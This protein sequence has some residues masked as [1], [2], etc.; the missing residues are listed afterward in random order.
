MTATARWVL[1][2]GGVQVQLQQMQPP[3]QDGC[4]EQD[5]IWERDGRRERESESEDDKVDP[6]W[7]GTVT[8]NVTVDVRREQ[9]ARVEECG[10]RRIR[11]AGGA[12]PWLSSFDGCFMIR[13]S[14]R[15]EGGGEIL[16]TT[17]RTIAAS[18]STVL[19]GPYTLPQQGR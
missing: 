7:T 2:S 15:G 1:G 8:V 9:G 10:G 12:A 6:R 18:T 5:G 11:A 3:M 16:M 4:R 19:N 14:A 13:G 17:T